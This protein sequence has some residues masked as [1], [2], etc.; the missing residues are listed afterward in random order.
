MF[1][2]QGHAIPNALQ[3][4]MHNIETS[5]DANVSL[6]TYGGGQAPI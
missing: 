4:R 5:G 6:I 2:K 1:F 3:N